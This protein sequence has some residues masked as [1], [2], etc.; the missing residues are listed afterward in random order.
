MKNATSTAPETIE[1]TYHEENGYL[2]PDLK[3]SPQTNYRIGKYGNLHLAYLKAHRPGTYTSLLTQFRLNEYLHE[4]DLQAKEMVRTIT[5]RL[6]HERGVDEALKAQDGLRWAQEMNNCKADAEEFV[7]AE[8][9]Y[10]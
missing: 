10:W 3:P 7:L 1:I 9:I 6:A 4:I 5:E 8:L 2:Y